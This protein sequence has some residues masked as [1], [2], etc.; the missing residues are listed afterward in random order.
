MRTRL[1]FAAVLVLAV[2]SSACSVQVRVAGAPQAA[3]GAAASP[4]AADFPTVLSTTTADSGRTVTASELEAESAAAKEQRPAGYRGL[5]VVVSGGYGSFDVAVPRSYTDVWRAGTSPDELLGEAARRDPAWAGGFRST[6]VNA[7]PDGGLR[8]VVLDGAPADAVN[9]LFVTLSGATGKS[10]DALA[11][12]MRADFDG[13]GSYRVVAARAVTVNG[14]Q[15]AY[16]EFT[17][18]RTDTP[19]VGI[20]VRIPDPPNNLLW[21]VTCEAPAAARAEIAQACATMA[22]TF[23]PLPKI[24]G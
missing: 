19:R 10:G 11:A 18:N 12:Q 7:A 16:A 2:L 17:I 21:G 13:K 5:T 9:A 4:S 24:S 1:T 3:Q 6:L 14:A 23:R 20:Q 15:G 8:A 22:G